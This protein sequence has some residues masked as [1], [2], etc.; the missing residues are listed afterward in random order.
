MVA[1]RG[2]R[3]V[4]WGLVAA[5]LAALVGTPAWGET[6]RRLERVE[7][8][9]TP[10]P[11]TDEE[12]AMPR[13]TSTARLRW[14]DGTTSEHALTYHVLYRSGDEA[15]G[16]Q[17]GLIVDRNGQP[18]LHSAPMGRDRRQLKGPFHAN[19]PDA[20]S[21]IRVDGARVDGVS[22]Q[23]LF[24][25]THFEY[26]PEAPADD[27][28]LV[29]L[30]G[31]LPMT[32]TLSILDQEPTEG[33]LRPVAFRTVDMAAAGGIWTPCAGSLTPWNTHLGSEEYEPDARVFHDRPLEP[34]NLYLGT[35]GRTGAQGGARAYRYGHAVEVSV[36]PDGSTTVNKR[37]AMGRLSL[38]L[39]RVMP[40]RRTAYLADDGADVIRAMFVADRPAD[41][42]AGTL[43]AARWVQETATG[44][45]RARL[46]WIRLGHA[47]QDEITAMI[48]GGIE[49]DAIFESATPQQVAAD[50]SRHADFRPVQVYPG[51]GSGRSYLKPRPGMETAAA[52]LETRRFAA[53]LG[54]TAEFT[55]MEG[56]AVDPTTRTLYT[57]LSYVENGMVEGDNGARPADHI[58]LDDRDGALQCGA[59]YASRLEGGHTDTEGRP[60]PS[61]WV[62]A[63]MAAV[64]TGAPQPARGAVP[65]RLDTCDTERVANPDNLAF[66]EALRT[67]F[68]G[69]DSSHHLNNFIWAFDVDR[70]TLTRIFSAPA[71]AENT[72]LQ[73]VDD[74]NGH[75]YLMANV[76][77][78]AATRELARYPASTRERMTHRIDRRGIVGYLGGLPGMAR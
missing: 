65:D 78:P 36:G 47:T 1:E 41:L 16:G 25:V 56:Q 17:A 35:P 2:P 70:G 48:D 18:I 7:F 33:T 27:G 50:P 61:D 54:A 51:T 55:K 42:S 43:Y 76:Q 6:A 30:Q 38:E 37:Y 73:M 62:A 32:M 12:R 29:S 74:Y 66:S 8:T 57:A 44:G 14:S 20:N 72:G 3:L 34:M 22:G 24:L 68:V 59:V 64:L 10:A 52:F 19:G 31:G 67:L 60:I 69:E 21:L 5:G 40:D 46:E 28:A 11:L 26:H 23:P 71:G 77:H 9:A 75:A 4:G 58:R 63:D 45:G 39:A 13:T 53:Y 15:K 49:F